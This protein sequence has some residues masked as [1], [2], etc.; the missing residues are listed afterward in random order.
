ML[1]LV[2]IDTVAKR[3]FNLSLSKRR[4]KERRC[5]QFGAVF[6]CG[7]QRFETHISDLYEYMSQFASRS[8]LLQYLLASP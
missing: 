5:L 4:S 7:K 2:E 6:F 3:K 1:S 8:I